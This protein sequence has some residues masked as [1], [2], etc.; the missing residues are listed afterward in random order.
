MHKKIIPPVTSKIVRVNPRQQFVKN[1]LLIIAFLLTAWLS[2]NF[3]L[4][5]SPVNDGTPVKQSRETQQHITVLEQERE[6]LKQGVT[7]LEQSAGKANKDLATI[8]ASSPAPKQTLSS[9]QAIPA[10]KPADTVTATADRVLTLRDIRLEQTDSENMFRIGFSVM[11]EASS[12]DRVV[13]TIWIAVNGFSGKEPKR[14]SFNMLSSARRSY[15]K[16]AFNTQQDVSEE[17]VLPEEFE[18]KNIQIEAKPYGDKYTGTMENVT[19]NPT[20]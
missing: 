17:L 5:R 19:W 13:G 15:I 7:E 1:T 11:N 9:A 10:P 20:E 18:P 4:S 16:M 2:Y 8:G 6:S 14:L 3:G 12:A